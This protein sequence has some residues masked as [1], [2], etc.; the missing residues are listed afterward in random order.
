MAECFG[1]TTMYRKEIIDPKAPPT[2]RQLAL[3]NGVPTL[4]VEYA[5]GRWIS[6]PMQSAG[7][8]GILNIMKYFKMIDGKIEPQPAVFPKVPGINRGKGAI[9]PRHGGLVRFLKM[10]GELIKKD[11]KFAE[12]YNLLGDVVEEIKLPFE[13]YV[14]SYPCGDFSDTSGELQTV[15]TGCILAFTFEHLKDI[16]EIE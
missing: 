13:G 12:I 16:S 11:E 10:P 6:E 15:N 4:E 7:V 5:D 2:I 14:W 9:R 8:R 1:F 3:M